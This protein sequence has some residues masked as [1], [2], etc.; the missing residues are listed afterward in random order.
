VA[1][2][3][4]AVPENRACLPMPPKLALAP[5]SSEA[6]VERGMRE[7]ATFSYRGVD[8]QYSELPDADTNLLFGNVLWPSADALC[9]ILID[10]V[11]GG[12]K[13]WTPSTSE[14]LGVPF[15]TL[16]S[17]RFGLTPD[18]GF[19]TVPRG[20]LEFLGVSSVIPDVTSR[21]VRVLEVGAGVGVPAM[22][23]HAL[24]A[25]VVLTDAEERLVRALQARCAIAEEEKVE[26]GEEGAGGQREADGRL[27]C[28]LMCWFDE[29]RAAVAE[30]DAAVAATP[31]PVEQ[32]DLIIAC[33]VLNPACEG[34]RCVPLLIQRRLRRAAGTRALLVSE[35]RRRETCVACVDGLHAAGLRVCAFQLLHGREAV[36]L[37]VDSLPAVGSQLL[38]V[39][40]WPPDQMVPAALATTQCARH[41]ATQEGVTA[42]PVVQ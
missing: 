29:A 28:E 37:N 18:S 39:A 10:E 5:E 16:V 15:D 22:V 33:E 3:L 1:A 26:E 31:P 20:C 21:S 34:E 32:Y 25:S 24:G 38:L 6:A 9:K 12:A 42:S 14:A 41:A 23:C 13:I 11:H 8:V 2:V 40:T 7:N 19:G 4:A 35:V 17:R 30:G 27:R 36:Q